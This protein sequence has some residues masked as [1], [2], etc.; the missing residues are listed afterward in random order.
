MYEC[1]D[2]TCVIPARSILKRFSDQLPVDSAWFS[3]FVI[4]VDVRYFWMSNRVARF[5]LLRFESA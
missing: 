3:P 2:S 1:R 5:A 4:D